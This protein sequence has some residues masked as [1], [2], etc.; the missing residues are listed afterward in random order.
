MIIKNPDS[1]RDNPFREVYDNVE[2]KTVLNH[3]DALPEFPYL[4]DIELTNQCNLKCVFCGQQAMTREKG[5]ISDEVFKKAT[6]ECALYKVPIRLIRFGEP[7][8]HKKIIEYCKYIKS[9]SLPLHITSNGLVMTD[10]DINA[11]IDAEVDSFLFS[12]QGAT[13]EQYEILRQ[14]NQYDKLTSN[15]LTMVRLRGNNP[16]PFIHI[17]STMTDESQEEIDDFVNYWSRIVDSVGFG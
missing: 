4:V 15:I 5:F 11:L 14:N 8:L 2:F 12:F 7:F 1:K 10:S 17:S 9:K 13:R 16:K 6:D 3:K